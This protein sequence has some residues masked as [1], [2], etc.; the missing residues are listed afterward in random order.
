ME[1]GEAA[2][3]SKQGGLRGAVHLSVLRDRESEPSRELVGIVSWV[4]L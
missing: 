2:S 4:T 3:S 1:L